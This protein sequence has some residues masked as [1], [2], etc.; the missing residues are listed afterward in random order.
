MGKITVEVRDAYGLNCT[1]VSKN[2][3]EIVTS[4]LNGVRRNYTV[5]DVRHCGR[6][7][8]ERDNNE[9]YIVIVE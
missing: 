2:A 9:D 6:P 5:I 4:L 7:K 8:A 1:V 3:L